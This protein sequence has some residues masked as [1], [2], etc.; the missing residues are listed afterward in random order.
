MRTSKSVRIR[1]RSRLCAFLVH[2]VGASLTVEYHVFRRQNLHW[3][4]ISISDEHHFG[5]SLALF[6]LKVFLHLSS[7]E[8]I[9]KV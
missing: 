1:H 8:A 3:Y 6:F 9:G 7:E 2:F 4:P 5:S